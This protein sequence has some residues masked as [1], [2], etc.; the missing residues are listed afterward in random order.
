MA[1]GDIETH[2]PVDW[3]DLVAELTGKGITV[4]DSVSLA[5]HGR[6]WAVVVI[7]AA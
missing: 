4:A 6:K 1:A 2:G 7:K 5:R 3:I